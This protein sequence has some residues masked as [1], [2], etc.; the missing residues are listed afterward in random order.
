MRV[1]ALGSQL[2]FQ[3]SDWRVLTFRNLKREVYGNWSS[4]E[5]IGQ[6]P[7]PFFQGASLQTMTMEI[8][9]DASLGVRPREMLKQIEQMVESGQAEILVIGRQRIGNSRWVITKSSEAWDVI[10][11]R[12]ELYRATMS[13]TLQE[14]F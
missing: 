9:L 4:M 6:K 1:G 13:L 3:V 12:G 5:R 2:V 10:Q 8:V 7:L 11:R 14:Y